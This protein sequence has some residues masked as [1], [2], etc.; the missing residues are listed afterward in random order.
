MLSM[1]DSGDEITVEDTR[2]I[3]VEREHRVK[4]LAREILLAADEGT[5]DARLR[6][7]LSAANVMLT[8]I[9]GAIADRIARKLIVRLDARLVG[10]PLWNPHISM[11]APTAFPGGYFDRRVR[12]V[13]AAT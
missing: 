12:P 6:E 8:E 1:R 11:P 3:A 7:R 4:G 5:P 2:A 9:D 10:L 13:S